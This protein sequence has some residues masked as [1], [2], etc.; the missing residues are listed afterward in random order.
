MIIK[1]K[2]NNRKA[3]TSVEYILMIAM[4]AGLVLSL[5]QFSGAID[6]KLA[7]WK[8]GA[9]NNIAGLDA[10][11]GTYDLSRADFYTPG[12]T[13][14]GSSGGVNTGGG[15]T[16]GGTGEGGTAGGAGGEEGTGG[17]GGRGQQGARSLGVNAPGAGAGQAQAGGTTGRV[18]FESTGGGGYNTEREETRS[19]TEGNY[20]E[21][22]ISGRGGAGNIGQEEAGQEAGGGE[23]GTSASLIKKNKGEELAGGGKTLAERDWGIGKFLIILLV[24]I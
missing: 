22:Q 9:R 18:G 24:I 20:E 16:G 23:K 15:T 10:N 11:Q 13:S 12:L 1:I 8:T 21:T 5:T 2:L 6:N 3:Q 7:S 4:V 17:A 19:S 14:K